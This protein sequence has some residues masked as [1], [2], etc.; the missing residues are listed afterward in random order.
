MLPNEMDSTTITKGRAFGFDPLT[1]DLLN[2]VASEIARVTRRWA[3]VF[4]DFESTH[5]W[6]DA[7]V[8]SGME[9]IR[10]GIFVKTNAAPQFSGDRPASP[11]EAIVIALQPGKKKWNGGG[12]SCAMGGV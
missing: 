1:S 2:A 3:L 11:A 5:L 6:R 9:Y 8:D 12:A 10:T 4:C 7:L